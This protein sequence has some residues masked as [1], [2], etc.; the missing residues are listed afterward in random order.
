MIFKRKRCKQ[1][2]WELS[3]LSRQKFCSEHC[4]DTWERDKRESESNQKGK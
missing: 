3:I 1:C 4:V 2:G